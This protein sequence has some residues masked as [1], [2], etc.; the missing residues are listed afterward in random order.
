MS[1]SIG[2]HHIRLTFNADG[3]TLDVPIFG[4]M[5]DDRVAVIVLKVHI[6]AR[7]KQGGQLLRLSTLRSHDN[8]R[9]DK[10]L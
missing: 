5:K 7:V 3:D 9:R 8:R 4:G 6:L 1:Y 2:S 10:A